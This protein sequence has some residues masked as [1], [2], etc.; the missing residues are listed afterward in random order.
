MPIQTISCRNTKVVCSLS[1]RNVQ[2]TLTESCPTTTVT[3]IMS[4]PQITSVA[5]TDRQRLSNCTPQI[6]TVTHTA[7]CKVHRTQ[8]QPEIITTPSPQPSMDVHTLPPGVTSASST[9]NSQCGNVLAISVG[10]LLMIIAILL[11]GWICTIALMRR[12][13]RQTKEKQR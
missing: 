4:S 8:S 13:H 10:L 5:S 2:H 7:E 3:K 11:I 6:T 12:T 1:V 9:L